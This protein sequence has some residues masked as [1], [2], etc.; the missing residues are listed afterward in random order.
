MSYGSGRDG[1]HPYRRLNGRFGPFGSLDF[2]SFFLF[3]SLACATLL[4]SSAAAAQPTPPAVV[5][6][7]RNPIEGLWKKEGTWAPYPGGHGKLK[8]VADGGGVVEVMAKEDGFVGVV[9]SPIQLQPDSVSAAREGCVHQEGEEIWSL[10]KAGANYP[11]GVEAF[12]PECIETNVTAVSF[13]LKGAG[14]DEKLIL[15]WVDFN[16]LVYDTQFARFE[17]TVPKPPPTGKCQGGKPSV[18]VTSI[19]GDVSYRTPTREWADASAGQLLCFDDEVNTGPGSEAVLVFP[20][21]STV[22]VRPLTQI[23]VGT[24]TGESTNPKIQVLLKA[25][26]IAA[27]VTQQKAIEADF[28]VRTPTATAGVRGTEFT[29]RYEPKTRVTTVAVTQ[30]TV[31]V[32]PAGPKPPVLVKAGQAVAVT[33]AGARPVA[34]AVLVPLKLYYSDALGDNFPTATLEGERSALSSGYR[35]VR[36][37]AYVFRTLQPGTVPLKLYYSDARHD[38]YTTG[39]A[40]GER[41]ALNSGYRFIRIEGYIYATE[42]PNSIPLKLYYSD[43]RQDNFT[44]GTADGE[45]D[46]QNSG[47][48]F[49]GIEGYALKQ[50]P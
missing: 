43:A 25:G 48:R 28:S 10:A 45:R 30:G 50:P 24:M 46:A 9:R 31:S 15:H 49:A 12:M 19:S 38:N 3:F 39:T 16:G 22:V 11:G 33:R 47:Y 1:F 44:T 41:N 34:A 13:R 23:I 5:A 27:K 2:L 21:G 18:R 6:A 40:W 8:W 26:E 36:I 20:N 7:P 29:V 35:Y 14:R 37:E 32:D 42:R 17:P 4:L